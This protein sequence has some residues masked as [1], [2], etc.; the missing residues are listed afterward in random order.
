M[1]RELIDIPRDFRK[2]YSISMLIQVIQHDDKSR[3]SSKSGESREFHER[4][5]SEIPKNTRCMYKIKE[6]QY[7]FWIPN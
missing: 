6:M 5:V 4:T 7:L 3:K 2:S 1:F